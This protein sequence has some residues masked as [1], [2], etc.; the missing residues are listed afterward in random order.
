MTLVTCFPTDGTG[1][2]FSHTWHWLHVL[3]HMARQLHV[4]LCLTLL[5]CFPTH[6][7]A[8]MFSHTWLCLHVFPH[9]TPVTCFATHVPAVTCFPLLD[10]FP[11]MTLLTCFPMHDTG[12]MFS[13]TWLGFHVFVS[14]RLVT[15][16]PTHDLT[17]MFSHA[18]HRHTCFLCL[19]LVTCILFHCLVLKHVPSISHLST[20]LLYILQL[21]TC[22]TKLDSTRTAT[23]CTM[24][25]SKESQ[26]SEL[27]AVKLGKTCDQLQ[28]I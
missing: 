27:S 24:K 8:H 26:K 22:F 12:C 20:S 10:S 25:L 4:F 23:I 5:T 7:S 21:V 15:C 9:M 11:H 14:F 28:N 17:Y 1:C 16:F 6:D 3:P 18:S 13:N 19:T 2:M